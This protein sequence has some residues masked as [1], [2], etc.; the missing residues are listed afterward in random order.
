MLSSGPVGQI[1]T[2]DSQHK[3]MPI[4]SAMLNT[5]AKLE[6]FKTLLMR[7]KLVM[8]HAKEFYLLK[9]AYIV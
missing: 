4:N 7:S 5:V 2:V 1:S 3:G 9:W 8:G 6:P